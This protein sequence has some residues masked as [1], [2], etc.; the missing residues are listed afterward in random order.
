M[1]HAAQIC[2]EDA[3]KA[4]RPLG[5]PARSP[6]PRVLRLEPGDYL[7]R[8]GD[9]R[10]CAYRVEK[11]AVAVFARRNTS[12]AR[13]DMAVRGKGNY[14]GLGCLARH[15]D[16]AQAVV[17]SI[18]TRLPMA[19]LTLVLQDNPKL[20]L[21]QADTI[22]KEFEY[23]KAQ[24][25]GRGPSTPLTRLAAFLVSESRLRAYEGLD[26]SEAAES[27]EC[28]PVG[29]LLGLDED[30]LAATVEELKGL[31][32]VEQSQAA[33]LRLKDIERLAGL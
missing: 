3:P 31:G 5:R 17:E 8:E 33:G 27:L 25:L 13:V 16:N 26:P 14:V 19:E 30:T 24:V 11:G 28:G 20:Q 32:F 18:V 9:L 21:E 4:A 10:T 29:S 23:R 15:F 6:P 2:L 12:A 7:Y 1:D 22:D